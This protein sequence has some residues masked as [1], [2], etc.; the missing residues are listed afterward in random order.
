[1][2]NSEQVSSAINQTLVEF[3]VGETAQELLFEVHDFAKL[4][5]EAQIRLMSETSIFIGVH[6]AGTLATIM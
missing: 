3:G 1:M 4:S 2:L 6:G 5:F